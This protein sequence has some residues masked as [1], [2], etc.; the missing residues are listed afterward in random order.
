M[1]KRVQ[2]YLRTT[3][4]VKAESTI[5]IAPRCRIRRYGE[6]EAK[7]L[8]KVI[9]NRDV[10]ARLRGQRD[11]YYKRAAG[12]EGKTVIEIINSGE[13]TPSEELNRRAEL[14]ETTLMSSLML[15]GDRDSFVRKA[16]GVRGGYF[17]LDVT[18]IGFG[19]KV[20]STS[21]TKQV[22]AGLNVGRK[23]GRRLKKNGFQ[24]LYEVVTSTGKLAARIKRALDWLLQS[25]TDRLASSAIV[26]TATA[27]ETLIVIGR[28]PTRRA[29]SERSAYLLSDDPKVR[30]Q[31][32]RAVK[33]FYSTRGSIVHGKAP[34]DNGDLVRTL[35]FG[36]RMVVLVSLVLA[37]NAD[38][39]NNADD[40]RQYCDSIRWGKTMSCSRPWSR[41]YLNTTL[42]RSPRI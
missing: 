6:A 28:E 41:R 13:I 3:R 36:D 19:T 23:A 1:A 37:A 11:F 31:I 26:K 22:P 14:A 32:S 17:D 38:R 24:A 8:A 33:S 2:H 34:S 35:E 16:I 15:R 42:D 39:W 27:M 29:L 9:R 18:T 21:Q 12:L 30:L 20:S 10:N 5:K 7:R 25:R 40:M 4:W